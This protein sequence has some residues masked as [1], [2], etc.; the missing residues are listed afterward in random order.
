M[1]EALPDY[2]GMHQ[3]PQSMVLRG[4]ETIKAYAEFVS[5]WAVL[6]SF[7]A[8]APAERI[9]SDFM[10][11]FVLELKV[12]DDYYPLPTRSILAA[13]PL[14]EPSP[15]RPMPSQLRQASQPTSK[16]SSQGT[17]AC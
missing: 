16:P 4:G 17:H 15:V 9:R 12:I 8:S 7:A 1:C 3:N 6:D 11:N 14:A 13:H 5:S 10:Q 2:G